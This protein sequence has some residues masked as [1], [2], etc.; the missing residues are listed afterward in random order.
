M[1]A[2]EPADTYQ[3]IRM[4]QPSTR[5]LREDK[6]SLEKDEEVADQEK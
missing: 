6:L 1:R 2:E 5:G 3:D 4:Y